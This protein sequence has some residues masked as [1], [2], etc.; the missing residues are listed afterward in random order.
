VRH[1]AWCLSRP[2]PAKRPSLAVRTDTAFLHHW[3]TLTRTHAHAQVKAHAF[4]AGKATNWALLRHTAPPYVPMH[5]LLSSG[6]SGDRDSGG[7]GGIL[8]TGATNPILLTSQM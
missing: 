8:D 6:Q 3:R 1:V 4:F 2:C 5:A 7:S